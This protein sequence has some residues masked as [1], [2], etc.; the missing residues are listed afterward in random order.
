MAI[1]SSRKAKGDTL[2]IFRMNEGETLG[3]ICYSAYK[4]TLAEK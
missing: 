3:S 4:S 1:N 2:C